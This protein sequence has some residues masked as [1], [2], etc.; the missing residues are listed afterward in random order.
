MVPL[1]TILLL[2]SLLIAIAYQLWRQRFEGAS[3]A[4]PSAASAAS[5]VAGD[6][7]KRVE[8]L[9]VSTIQDLFQNY[10]YSVDSLDVA[11]G[12]TLLER[13]P[14]GAIYKGD[15]RVGGTV[16][17]LHHLMNLYFLVESSADRRGL[18]AIGSVCMTLGANP[19]D[20]YNADPP[21]FF[22]AVL[23][24]ELGFASELLRS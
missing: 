1:I 22:K 23:T 9:L 2:S 4:L 11:G 20:G 3:A 15:W 13:V 14:S 24:R 7:E 12:I 5:P 21:V 17:V 16:P 19:G 6:A 18:I 8:P 10:I